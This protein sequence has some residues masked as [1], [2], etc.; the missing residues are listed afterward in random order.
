MNINN[1]KNLRKQNKYT[2]TDVANLLGLTQQRYNHYETGRREPDSETLTQLAKLFNVSTDYLLG[3]TDTPIE[4]STD[5][6]SITESALVLQKELSKLDIDIENEKELETI[7][8]FIDS[9]KEMLKI[10]MRKDKN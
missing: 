5:S 9:N 2:Q 1:L 6:L 7:L 8:K 4:S 10:L 3:I